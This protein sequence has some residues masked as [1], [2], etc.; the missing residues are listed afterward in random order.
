MGAIYSPVANGDSRNFVQGVPI[1]L[2]KIF[3][4]FQD[5]SVNT[6]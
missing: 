3:E 5:I 4:S 6:D 1:S 2:W